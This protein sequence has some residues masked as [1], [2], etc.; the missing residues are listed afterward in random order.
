MKAQGGI[1]VELYSFFNL[2]TKWG[3]WLAPYRGH[4][5][6]KK[7][8]SYS[9][10]RRLGG[11]EGWLGHLWQISLLLGFDPQTVQPVAS[12][13]TGHAVVAHSVQ[14]VCYFQKYSVC[15]RTR[16]TVHSVMIDVSAIITF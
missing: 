10:C 2:K 4:F 3:G 6:P 9:F 1:D 12:L 8:A 7:D 16:S 5:T 15:L 14:R 11:P 13:C